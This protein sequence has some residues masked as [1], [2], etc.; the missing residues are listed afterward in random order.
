MI[1]TQV[2]LTEEEH[3]A[4][5]RIA[6]RSGQRRSA[7]IRGA[8]DDFIARQDKA[9][10]LDRLRSARGVGANRDDV[11]DVRALRAGFERY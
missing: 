4:I 7:V 3:T 2:Y 8:L 11:P 6:V 1:R 10:Q 5:V 9:A